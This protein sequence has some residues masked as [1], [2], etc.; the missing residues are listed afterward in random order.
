MKRIL[1]LLL[2]TTIDC[3]L[4]ADMADPTPFQIVQSNGDTIL[5]VQR[6]DEFVSCYETLQTGQVIDKD[7]KGTWRYVQAHAD[8]LR[9]T[10]TV[11]RADFVQA[12][13]VTETAVDNRKAIMALFRKT[14][15]ATITYRDSIANTYDMDDSITAQY[16]A[17]RGLPIQTKG[18]ATPLPTKGKMK[19]LT[20]LVDFKDIKFKDPANVK[21]QFENIMNMPNYV[22]PNTIKPS[23]PAAA[24][25]SSLYT[26]VPLPCGRASFFFACPSALPLPSAFYKAV[27]MRDNEPQMV[28]LA[29]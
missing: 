10:E 23:I 24:S 2:F 13:S 6:G 16:V 28:I 25:F 4:Y 18:L 27:R 22:E 20:I 3:C 29:V 19:I 7:T 8:T 14:R 26:Y 15:E 5:V 17:E 9:L 11:R 1:L 12:A 21:Q